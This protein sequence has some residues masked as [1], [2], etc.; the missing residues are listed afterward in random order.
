[1]NFKQILGYF[2]ID[3]GCD[4]LAAIIIAVLIVVNILYSTFVKYALVDHSLLGSDLA[5]LL[6][7][8]TNKGRYEGLMTEFIK[9]T[10]YILIS[11]KLA[12]MIPGIE[13]NKNI[14]S[15]VIMSLFTTLIA[16][17]MN[18]VLGFLLSGLDEAGVAGDLIDYIPSVKDTPAV[19]VWEFVLASLTSFVAYYLMRHKVCNQFQF[20]FIFFILLFV[21]MLFFRA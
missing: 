18:I 21:G 2:N 11:M 12:P 9:Y 6:S 5:N 15:L 8:R 13:L 4:I 7:T 10:L 19:L 20:I 17:I 14:I 3:G 1:M 16:I